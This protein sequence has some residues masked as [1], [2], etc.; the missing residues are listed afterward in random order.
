MVYLYKSNLFFLSIIFLLKKIHINHLI[1]YISIY[2]LDINTIQIDVR[3]F[4]QKQIP[5]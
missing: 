5:K 3:L 2:L 4:S 1:N